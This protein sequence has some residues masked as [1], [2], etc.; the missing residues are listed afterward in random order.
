MTVSAHVGG[1][2]IEE[3][4]GMYGPALLLALG[5]GSARVGA[6]LRRLCRGPGRDSAAYE[7]KRSAY[8]ALGETEECAKRARSPF[9]SSYV[10]KLMV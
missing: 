4:L 1:I 5:A 10:K 9:R 8:H 3:T 7:T 6:R 2:P